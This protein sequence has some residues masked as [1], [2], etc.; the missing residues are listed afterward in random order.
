MDELWTPI[1]PNDQ[2]RRT[3]PRLLIVMIAT[4][5]ILFG[6]W[7]VKTGYKY[8]TPTLA[9]WLQMVRTRSGERL[10]AAKGNFSGTLAGLKIVEVVPGSPASRAGLKFGDVLIGYNNR[11][12]TNQQEIEAV[13]S[14]FERQHDQTV[15]PATAE[16]ALYRDG[17]MTVKTMRVP[18]G[19]LGI[20]TREWT[21]AGA[22]V[23]DAI[24]DRDDYVSAEK[25]ANE[26]AASGQYTDDQVLHMRM[27]CVN[28]EKDGERIRQTQV[29]ELYRKYAPDKLTF[30]G[31]YDLLYNKRYRAGAAVFERY[32]KIKKVDVSTELN[33]AS[34]Y[35]EIDKYDEAE[36]LI[37]RVLARPEDDE[38]APSEYGLSVLSNIRGKIYMGHG[39]YDRAQE[40]FQ[41][42]LERYPGDPYY[43]LALLYCAT[44]RDVGGEKPGEFEA[45]YKSVSAQSDETE[46]LMGYHIDALRA[47]VL[48][49]RQRVS[50][51]RAAVVRWKDSADAKRYIPI[52]WRRFPDGSQIIDNWNTL[53][54]NTL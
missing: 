4:L 15:K 42:A 6:A 23:E 49:K 12:I 26:A 3:S 33:L 34:C 52:F 5:V 39:Q 44:R 45:A 21:F 11:P 51:A 13:M 22:F 41:A 38:N 35:T 40:R 25:Y 2:Q 29:D 31:N 8:A 1:T 16:L 24:V 46:R 14:F 10:P 48:V 54:S 19:K 53:M 50:D 36:A 7:A 43:T 37:S 28:N 20:Y 17:D 27:L 18:I 47:F 30:F 9:R 32:L